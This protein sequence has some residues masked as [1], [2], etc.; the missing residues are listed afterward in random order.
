MDLDQ[1][2]FTIDAQRAQAADLLDT[3]TE[4]QWTTPSLC[5]GWRVREVAAHLTLAHTGIGKGVRS[6]VRA[7]GS[8]DRMIRDT[9]IQQAALPTSDYSAW[10]R[11]VA[12]SRRL[13][14][15]LTPMEPLLDILVHQQDIARPLGI[16]LEMPRDAAAAAAQRSWALGF[17]FWAKRRLRGLRLTAADAD[18]T[19]GEGALV[20][21]PIGE[22]LMLITG[23][24]PD[25]RTLDGPGAA[26]LA[27]LVAQREKA[28]R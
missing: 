19:A 8:F 22:L 10:L 18:W 12:G 28:A 1:V 27:E 20:R 25:V 7:R 21:A 9:A 2:W 4:Q 15:G 26:R 16:P 24:S 14:V 6:L 5:A 13:V 11:S 3:L 23:R 17:P